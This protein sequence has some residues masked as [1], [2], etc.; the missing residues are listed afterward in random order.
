MKKTVI[1]ILSALLVLLVFTSCAAKSGPSVNYDAAAEPGYDVNPS[2][3]KS[4]TENGRKLIKR[5]TVYAETKEYEETASLL[6]RAVAD[7]GGYFEKRSETSARAD[8][9]KR[10]TATVR[11]PADKT[12]EFLSGIRGISNVTSFEKSAED[13]TGAYVDIEARLQTLEAEREGLLNMIS[14]VDSASQYD[15]WYKLHEAIS[16]KEQDI[17][18]YRAQLNKYDE[19]SSYSTFTLY[20]NEVK[21]YTEPE[22]EGF[23]VRLKD[24]FVES[25]E[26]FA[27][28]FKDFSVAFVRA[29]PSLLTFAVISSVIFLA[30][31]LPIRASVKRK[32]KA[33]NK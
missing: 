17:A 24:A 8:G 6:D 19:L 16:Q 11:I 9:E 32:R 3:E 33:Q 14:S 29:F 1:I 7:A 5:Y 2:E 27:E 23:G 22:K 20:L 28:G 12:E 15:F 4:A 21:I 25:W 31:F 18:S 10:L 13:V 26:S 30:V